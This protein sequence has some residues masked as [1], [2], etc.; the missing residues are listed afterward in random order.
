MDSLLNFLMFALPGGFVGSVLS[1]LVS[2]RDRDNDMLSKLQ[3]SINMLSEE[4][5]KILEENIQLRRE[6][7]RLQ[8]NQEEILQKQR[9]LLTEVEHLRAEIAKLTNNHN[10]NTNIHSV[11]S[12]DLIRNDIDGLCRIPEEHRRRKGISG[13]KPERLPSGGERG[14]LAPYGGN[15]SHES[16]ETEKDG[17]AGRDS[18]RVSEDDAD[19]EKPP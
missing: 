6:N 13:R 18:G 16:E 5:R 14:G 8:A 10:E 3:A 11:Y 4:N 17:D 19:D 7:A 9:A 2:R 15:R 12:R 1:W